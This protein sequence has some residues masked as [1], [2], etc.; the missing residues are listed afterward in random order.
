[1]KLF[2]NYLKF[3]G[4]LCCCLMFSVGLVSAYD[5]RHNTF[6]YQI[7]T[8]PLSESNSDNY[9][10]MKENISFTVYFFDGDGKQKLMKTVV[11]TTSRSATED[12]YFDAPT[13]IGF[14]RIDLLSGAYSR[15]PV[16]SPIHLTCPGNTADGKPR[17][18]VFDPD[19]PIGNVNFIFSKNRSENRFENLEHFGLKTDG[20]VTIRTFR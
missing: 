15:F 2:N 5:V 11:P 8:D 13:E 4:L 9:G 19:H 10:T 16:W 6:H 14:I 12:G 17:A 20:P 3:L 18:F 1:M 7:P